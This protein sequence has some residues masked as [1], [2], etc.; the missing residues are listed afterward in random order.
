MPHALLACL[1]VGRLAAPTPDR[2]ALMHTSIRLDAPSVA[3][4]TAAKTETNVA[5]IAGL[6]A[7]FA[8]LASTIGQESCLGE[9][10]WHCAAKGALAGALVGGAI[11][12]VRSR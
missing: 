12:W 3:S 6:S 8:V 4:A 9:P 7:T 5:L 11:V 10:R 1:M 2:I